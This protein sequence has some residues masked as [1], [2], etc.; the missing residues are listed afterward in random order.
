MGAIIHTPL[1]LSLSS[2]TLWLN[3]SVGILVFN[4]CCSTP[5]SRWSR[6]GMESDESNSPPLVHVDSGQLQCRCIHTCFPVHRSWLPVGILRGSLVLQK[7]IHEHYLRGQA[8]QLMS[9]KAH[10]SHFL[11]STSNFPLMEPLL[12][13]WALDLSHEILSMERS[14]F[15]LLF[16]LLWTFGKC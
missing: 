11:L 5:P 14:L 7:K 10:N 8:L 6:L 13:S 9:M 4:L 16:V 1:F 3:S 2:Q 12:R 15:P